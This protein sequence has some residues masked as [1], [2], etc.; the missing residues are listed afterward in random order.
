M[1][2]QRFRKKPVTIEALRLT[3]DNFSEVT[4]W[5]KGEYH[6]GG[7]TGPHVCVETL[8]GVVS[9]HPGDWIIKGIK[10]EFYPCAN[11]IFKET[12]ESVQ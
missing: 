1:E 4:L 3:P 12:Y 9:A 8:N 7:L 10:G 11:R 6:P 2:P 5:C